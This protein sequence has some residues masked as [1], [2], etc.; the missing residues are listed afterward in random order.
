MASAPELLELF[1]GALREQVAP[2]SWTELDDP[3]GF[4]AFA[5]PIDD[6]FIAVVDVDK[7][8]VV[9]DLGA[10]RISE[11][12]AGAVYLPLRR[13]WPLLGVPSL[14]PR[15]RRPLLEA[16]E[17]WPDWPIRNADDATAVAT[18]VATL[19][20][21][22]AFA[23][24][25]ANLDT[26]L[27]WFDAH[28]HSGGYEGLALL[29][30]AGRFDGARARLERFDPTA[31]P[32]GVDPTGGQRFARQLG[33]WIDSGGDPRLRAAPSPPPRFGTSEQSAG[34]VWNRAWAEHEAVQAVQRGAA[35]RSRDELRAHLQDEL[36][37]RDLT[38]TPVWVE[39]TLDT[40]SLSR[41]EQ[42][43]RTGELL[44]RLGAGI[45]RAIRDR[46]L[47]D[48]SVPELLAPPPRAVYAIPR[49]HERARTAVRLDPNAGAW[50][51][52]IYAALPKVIGMPL[53]F[54]AWLDWDAGGPAGERATL[55]VSV[56]PKR[57]GCLDEPATAAF[58]PVM[59][60]AAE[61]DE[62]PYTAAALRHISA[63]DRYV[64]EVQLPGPGGPT[65]DPS[66]GSSR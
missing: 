18:R 34:T 44:G 5:R 26:M 63:E 7:Q 12:I 55:A 50:L 22:Q 41:G 64:L 62:L 4:A 48:L 66:D 38:M 56:G 10:T 17:H 53:D 15:V 29:A 28:G 24:T 14:E 3:L 32:D 8:W 6:E 61:R 52:E 16:G 47:P 39:Q 51:D 35:G 11:V 25:H 57:V 30:A 43:Q 65:P 33:R 27:E 58:A 37:A 23:S 40:L 19:I 20:A 21:D 42:W 49:H 36:D 45:A 54:D 2:D 1:R 46:E 59:H 9:P 31:F 13:L 60:A